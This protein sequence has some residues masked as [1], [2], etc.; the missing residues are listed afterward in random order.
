MSTREELV[1]VVDDAAVAAYAAW[2]IARDAWKA[3]EEA[4]IAY[5]KENT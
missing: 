1:K 4:L 2:E 3:A 5:D